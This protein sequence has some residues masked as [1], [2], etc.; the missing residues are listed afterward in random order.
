MSVY[1]NASG[2]FGSVFQIGV[3]GP[4]V[5]QDPDAP[6]NGIGVD[7]DLHIQYDNGQCIY[8]KLDG[9]WRRLI[10]PVANL[11]TESVYRGVPLSVSGSTDIVFVRRNPYTADSIDVT[12]DS[13]N[14][15]VDN[16]PGIWTDVILPEGPE[17]KTIVVKDFSSKA[18]MYNIYIEDE[19]AD[20]I[21]G[22]VHIAL[23]TDNSSTE[24]QYSG[25]EW[26]VIG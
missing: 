6:D 15:T 22:N 5:Y 8:V 9:S 13:T 18:S 11:S 21:D 16:D 1:R 12:I 14:I 26:R 7:G 23:V 20:P 24:L 19:E 25:G 4:T 3:G 2:T 10:N 17:G